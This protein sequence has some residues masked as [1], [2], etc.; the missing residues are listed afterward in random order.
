VLGAG[1][2]GEITEPATSSEIANKKMTLIL[3]GTFENE[4][5]I[6]DIMMAH[7]PTLANDRL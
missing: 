6:V 5:T 1:A 3:T 4:I 2:A 7:L